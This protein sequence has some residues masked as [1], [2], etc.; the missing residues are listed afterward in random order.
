MS[1]DTGGGAFVS[2][3]VSA[4]GDF[5]GRDKYEIR[6]E[7]INIQV[8]GSGDASQEAE[9]WREYLKRN[10][11]PYKG[12][13]PY[14][15]EDQFLF[16]GRDRE[17]EMALQRIGQQ[18]ALVVHGPPDVGKTSLLT[19]GIIPQL[20]QKHGAMTVYL[21]D[22]AR[23]LESLSEKLL[24]LAQESGLELASGQPLAAVARALV[25]ARRQGMVLILDQFERFL[26]QDARPRGASSLLEELGRLVAEL[27][28][29]YLRLVVAVR[30]EARGELDRLEAFVPELWRQPIHLQPL[31]HDQARQAIEYPL[32]NEELNLE[33]RVFY[34]DE[35][36]EAR[37]LPDLTALNEQ[38]P[39][40]ILPAELQIV[41]DSLYQTA[42]DRKIS[43]IN[44]ALYD[45]ISQGKGA[46]GIIASHLGQTL[47]AHLADQE[48]LAC[49]ILA[50]MFDPAVGFWATPAQ[51]AAPGSDPGEIQAVLNEMVMA[52]LLLLR[53][54]AG[55]PEY[56]F[57][58][59]SIAH[60]ALQ[61]TGPQAQAVY[62][63]KDEIE[64][65][66][67]AWL[68]RS[69]SPSR[70]Q[71][72]YLAESGA[73]LEPRPEQALLLLRSAVSK[74]LEAEPWGSLLQAREGAGAALVKNIEERGTPGAESYNRQTVLNQA[75]L[76]LDLEDE[77]LPERSPVFPYGPLSW[78]AANHPQ[79]ALRQTLALAL[80]GAYDA[81]AFER[82]DA[83]IEASAKGQRRKRRAELYGALI[84]A[85]P[86]Y[87]KSSAYLPPLDRL[88]IWWWRLRRRIFLGRARLASMTLGGA[89]G[90]GLSLGLLRL[91]T[92]AL[93]GELVGVQFA[94]AFY[95]AALLG[96]AL[97][98]GMALADPL[99]R[100]GSAS[101]A[102][103]AQDDFPPPPG[104]AIGLGGLAFG[105]MHLAA[106]W[107]NGLSI[108]QAPLVPLLGFLA[109]LGLSAAVFDP[110]VAG[111][112]LGFGRWALRLGGIGLF[113]A[114]LQITFV[115]AGNKGTG[116]VLTWSGDYYY[117]RLLWLVESLAVGS[118]DRFLGWAP[119]IGVLDAAVVGVALA[120][121]ITAGLVLSHRWL[122]IWQTYVQNSLE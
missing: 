25:T 99:H 11:R 77:K 26:A 120:L 83:S 73:Q 35:I 13:S 9:R 5:I 122:V 30:D 45:E 33:H 94:I 38:W 7:R 79:A 6:G 121:G 10:V 111:R 96:G 52:E 66:W 76:V 22:Y 46:E 100:L 23:P 107:L 106:V 56:A 110:P 20:R 90:A 114:L 85:K 48:D 55:Q 42:R 4:A 84:D 97:C 89:I 47:D 18:Q 44:Q 112:R 69:A 31:S 67:S 71:L 14:G 51:L 68:A 36:V 50:R 53:V 24:T 108:R 40:Q 119:A 102:G 61:L 93:T 27:D 95:F 70:S 86:T 39:G 87:K 15:V 78:A 57:A 82:I 8:Y 91:L 72:H 80:A 34:A 103:L 75:R 65:I 60:A 101:P 19:A 29:D 58:S 54:I 63:A 105:I 2:G 118:G 17:I 37:L 49:K 3:D 81:Q 74:R 41:C 32:E 1:V 59:H 16:T 64:R 116:I 113:F 117:A 98:L 28:K 104:L 12:L 21:P 109:G 88:A 62:Q 115:L 92:G 43:R